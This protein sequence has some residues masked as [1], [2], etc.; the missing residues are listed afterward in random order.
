[1]TKMLKKLMSRGVLTAQF[2]SNAI[3]ESKIAQLCALV[4]STIFILENSNFEIV[5]FK[6]YIFIL[7]GKKFSLQRHFKLSAHSLFHYSHFRF[8]L[9]S[10]L[11]GSGF[12]FLVFG[13]KEL[14]MLQRSHSI[15][16]CYR[17]EIENKVCIL[18]FRV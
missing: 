13:S 9:F 4:K 5:C 6:R 17:D 18:K 3:F 12:N 15:L 1:M 16:Q 8:K 11:A 2:D 7:C 14:K 10:S